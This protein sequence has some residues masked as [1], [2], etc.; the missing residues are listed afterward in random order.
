AARAAQAARAAAAAR[1]LAQAQARAEALSRAKADEECETCP[2]RRNMLISRSASPQAAQHILDAQ[3]AGQPRVLTLDKNPAN[4]AARRSAATSRL[5][6][7][8]GMDRDEYPPATFAEGG[9]TASVRHVSRSDNRSAGGQMTS[10]L[11]GLP[12]G[13]RITVM[14]VP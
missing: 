12:D 13:C 1:A 14:V 6:T 5:P 2:C 3:A 9:A 7:M 4:V 8:P 11:A 10:Q